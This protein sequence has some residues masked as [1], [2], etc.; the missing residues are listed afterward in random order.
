MTRAS[1]L[2]RFARAFFRRWTTPFGLAILL[3]VI[4]M[5][6]SAPYVFP[7]DPFAMV[8]R[9]LQWP[10]EN[11]TYPLGS[12]MLGRDILAGIFYGARVSS[13]SAGWPPRRPSAP[14]CSSAPSPGTTAA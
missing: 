2:R 5:A 14:A 11:R 1:R 10:G 8:T 6:V 12:D 13:P 7:E 4:A 3:G 9:P